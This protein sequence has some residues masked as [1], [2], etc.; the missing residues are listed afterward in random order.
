M[1]S[2]MVIKNEGLQASL[3]LTAEARRKSNED[4][5]LNKSSANSAVVRKNPLSQK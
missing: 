3:W 5:I 2:Q 4:I 1:T